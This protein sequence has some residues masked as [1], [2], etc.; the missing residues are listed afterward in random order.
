MF[1]ERSA[2]RFVSPRALHGLERE[3]GQRHLVHP[4]FVERA[5]LERVRRVAG[6]L[7]VA[8]VERVAV[9]DQRPARRQVIEIR[10]QS[11]GV[12]RDEH[13]RR[14]AGREDVVV[15]VVDLEAGDAG[16]R[17]GRRANLGREV[18]QCRK[19][20]AEERGLARESAAGQL[21]AVAGIAG[22]PDDDVLQL[23]DGLGHYLSREV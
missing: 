5:V 12:H 15:G 13:V 3:R 7:E 20:V 14:V 21:H 22:E 23:L 2:S 1:F 10:A 8:V 19:V 16:Q 17:A 18:G 9:D 4:V 6:L 11:R